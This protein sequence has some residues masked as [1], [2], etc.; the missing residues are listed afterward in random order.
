MAQEWPDIPLQPPGS[1]DCEL[2]AT[3]YLTTLL[4]ERRTPEQVRNWP[5][6]GQR[7][8][9]FYPMHA[10]GIAPVWMMYWGPAGTQ[11]PLGIM[12]SFSP[13]FRDWCKAYVK[14]GCVGYAHVFLVERLG[15]AVVLLEAD[16]EGVLL[17]D[18]VRGLVRD[19][20][21]DFESYV[22]NPEPGGRPSHVKAWYRLTSN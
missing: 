17:A 7:S 8:Q 18:P 19:T 20:W 15:H 12:Y 9:G 3:S 1:E 11:M 13:G 10:L 21:T 16:D 5:E 22:G 6:K 14:H 4:G 2:Y